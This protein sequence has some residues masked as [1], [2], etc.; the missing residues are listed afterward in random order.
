MFDEQPLTKKLI[1]HDPYLTKEKKEKTEERKTN[2]PKGKNSFQKKKVSS[3]LAETAKP[4]RIPEI[5]GGG[6]GGR[7]FIIR[8][9]SWQRFHA[10][11]KQPCC[12]LQPLA[13]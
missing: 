4:L 12:L 5:T 3:K 7:T 9:N 13:H 11:K 2:H 8:R 1:Y 6:E 10:G